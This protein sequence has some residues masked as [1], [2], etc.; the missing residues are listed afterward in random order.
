[1]TQEQAIDREIEAAPTVPSQSACV[2]TE[3]CTQFQQA[4]E[5][6]GRRWVGAIIYVLLDGPSRFNELLAR[7]PNLSD[8]LLT[9]RLRELESAGVVTREVHPGPPVRVVYELT[10]AGRALSDVISGLVRWS[11]D[12]MPHN[13]T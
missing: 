10:S 13:R 4:V 5:F 6:L 2:T 3:T 11:H 7:V 9:E 8:R 12:W 1:M